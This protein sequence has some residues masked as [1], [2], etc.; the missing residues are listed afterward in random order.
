MKHFG[1]L[2]VLGA[3]LAVSATY[4]HATV[5]T[6]SAAS[7]PGGTLLATVN[8]VADPSP[9][10]GDLN[11]FDATY[12]ESVYRGGTGALCPTC[13]EFVY[14]ITNT[15]TGPG[16]GVIESFTTVDFSSATTVTGG[17]LS[18]GVDGISLGTDIGGIIHLTFGQTG[19]AANPIPLAASQQEDTFILY[20]DN[21]YYQPGTMTFQDG[22]TADEPALAPALT[23]E[24]GSLMLLGTGL[25]GGAGVLMR[26]RRLTV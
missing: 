2:A 19:N 8:G 13:L 12:T 6:F 7:L 16:A 3:A 25:I 11:P 5:I 1:K 22:V 26:R 4:A 20:T 9:K 24:P 15:A 10:S 18:D 23:P 17:I 21:Q 14:S